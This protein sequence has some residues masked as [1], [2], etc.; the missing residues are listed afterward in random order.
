M[1]K[2]VEFVVILDD[3]VRKRHYHKTDKGR[4]LYFA[5]QL[6]VNV[7]GDWK[8]VVRYDCSHRFSHQD[9]YD[10]KG[11]KTKTSLELSFESALTY[12]EWD[13]NENWP[14]YREQF[15]KGV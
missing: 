15:L 9:K 8:P 7:N 6:E 14:E 10:I 13:I 11:R 5:V 2:T 3:G 4:V 1:G 12:G